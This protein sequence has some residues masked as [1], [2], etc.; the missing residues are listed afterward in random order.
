MAGGI[1]PKLLCEQVENTAAWALEGPTDGPAL[2][3]RRALVQGRALEPV[4]NEPEHRTAY[5]ELMLAA[6]YAT[7]ATFVPT[8]VDTRIRYHAWQEVR[9]R[10][11]FEAMVAL[12]DHA[13]QH[14]SAPAISART[15]DVGFGPVS[16]HDGEW[17]SVRAGALGRAI[18]LKFDDLVEHIAGTIDRELE[19]ERESFEHASRTRGMELD[20]L[21]VGCAIAHNLGDLSRV[22]VD[23]AV[24]GPVAAPYVARY[25]RLGHEDS[26]HPIKTFIRV[27][28]VNKAVTALENHRFL[29]LRRPRAL[30]RHRDLLLPTGPFF[31]GWG[32]TIAT[33]P[34]LDRAARAEI[35]ETLVD[36]HESEPAQQGYLRA[37]AGMHSATR[38]GLDDLA[39]ELPAKLRRS[40]S[41]GLIREALG[42]SEERFDAR[43]INRFKQAMGK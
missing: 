2:T 18:H 42:V 11:Q 22:V 40:V 41:G 39:K 21:R 6:H 7:V 24:K 26:T 27:G 35:L 13:A 37:M 12:V 10:A 43:M 9:D 31:D 23:W 14:W 5:F 8:D 17:F 20:A 30:R 29:P 4:W 25:G 33:H 38:G 32:R 16:G 3:W 36:A 34:S 28:A 15:T 19:R 1:A